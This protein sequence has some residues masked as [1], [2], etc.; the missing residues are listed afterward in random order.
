MRGIK[1]LRTVVS[2]I[3]GGNTSHSRGLEKCGHNSMVGY[4]CCVDWIW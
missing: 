1:I 2:V 4:Q 3:T